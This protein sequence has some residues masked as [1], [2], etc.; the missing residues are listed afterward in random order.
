MEK[1][2]M[3]ITGAS[4]GMGKHMVEWFKDKG[5]QLVLHYHDHAPAHI[6]SDDIFV[7]QSDLRDPM[8]I[9]RMIKSAL[10]R[11]GK[12][13]LLINNAGISRSA[14]SW[15]TELDAWSET[16]M[17]NLTAPFLTSKAVVPGMRERKYGRILN[18]S[19]VVA[20]TGAIG[21]AAY[22]ASK[23]GLI[24][25]TKTQAKELA[26]S[27]ITVNAL[28]L[29]YFSTGMIGDVPTELQEEII[30][31][32]PFKRFGDPETVCKTIEWLISDESAYITGQVINLNGGMYA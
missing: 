21:T 9:E 31:T 24:G 13:D 7:I 6:S 11:F 8:Q 20:Q 3:L 14:M 15:K 32:I 25:L 27:G 1:K 10:E 12:I 17:V 22:G 5:L 16:M 23:A 29:G 2:V 28:A 30:K 19:S 18:I 26:G 4:G